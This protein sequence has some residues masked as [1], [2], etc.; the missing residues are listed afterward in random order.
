MNVL[1][2]K[3]ITIKKWYFVSA[4]L[5]A[6]MLVSCNNGKTVADAFGNFETGEVLISAEESGR[7]LEL[8]ISEGDYVQPKVALGFIDTTMLLI[9]RKQLLASRQALETKLNQI[10]KTAA[11]Q[12]AQADLMQKELQRALK[13]AAGDA[14]TAQNLDRVE[15]EERIARRQLE[16][17]LTQT[18]QVRAEQKVID[19][20]I[21]QINEQ[22]RRSVIMSP[23]AGTVLQKYAEEG[24]LVAAGKPLFKVANLNDVY[25]R[26]YVSGGQLSEIAIGQQVIVRFDKGK[27]DFYETSGVVSWIA[28]SAEFTPKIIQTKDERVDLVYAIKVKVE[29]NG[30]IKIGMP[31]EVIFKKQDND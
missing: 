2:K 13:L 10:S 31:G 15:G 26:A 19:A 11:V 8:S 6:T 16:Q 4:I 22:I 3:A 30:Q 1:F 24:E 12:K 14:I 7:L 20:Q 5:L 27:A 17:I 9:K 29:N 23:I 25:L 21:E 28:S 18:E